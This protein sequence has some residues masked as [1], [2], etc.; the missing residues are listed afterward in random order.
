MP[1][2]DIENGARARWARDSRPPYSAVEDMSEVRAFAKSSDLVRAYLPVSRAAAASAG[3][4][5]GFAEFDIQ[6]SMPE[7]AKALD[8]A[9]LPTR[10]ITAVDPKD[11]LPDRAGFLS[12]QLWYIGL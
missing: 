7:A 10:R 4:S 2:M 5:V 1:F 11:A 6:K 8:R 9:N 3:A 12:S